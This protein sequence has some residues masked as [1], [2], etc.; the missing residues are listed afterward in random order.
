MY[1]YGTVLLLLVCPCS[2]V[3]VCNAM[4]TCHYLEVTCIHNL[5]TR[6][7]QCVGIAQGRL[8]STPPIHSLADS[9]SILIESYWLLT[10]MA[11][12]VARVHVL[13]FAESLQ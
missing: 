3:I 5:Y 2:E 4:V 10:P 9:P 8:H 1:V 6:A 11:T 7:R 13:E 12:K